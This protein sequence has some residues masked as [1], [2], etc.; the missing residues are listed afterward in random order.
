MGLGATDDQRFFL[1][2]RRQRRAGSRSPGLGNSMRPP[3]CPP[4]EAI[5]SVCHLHGGCFLLLGRELCLDPG[6]FRDESERPES[7][8]RCELGSSMATWPT[9]EAQR[10]EPCCC[11]LMPGV[12]TLLFLESPA[13][14]SQDAARSWHCAVSLEQLSQ[15]ARESPLTLGCC[16]TVPKAPSLTSSPFP[17][18]F[19]FPLK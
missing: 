11:P 1:L 14:L 10:R 9:Q 8:L 6:H 4:S 16:T 12:E 18:P 2:S 7:H 15:F 13:L 5:P 3:D 17:L 19:S